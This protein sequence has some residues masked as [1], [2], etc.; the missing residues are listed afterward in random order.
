MTKLFDVVFRL[1]FTIFFI[2]FLT[3]MYWL[4]VGSNTYQQAVII[5][6]L[7]SSVVVVVCGIYEVLTAKQAKRSDKFVWIAAF[8][9][10]NVLAALLYYQSNESKS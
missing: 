3:G 6:G 2:A 5:G 7:A 4:I 1:G 10:C 8:L 9:L